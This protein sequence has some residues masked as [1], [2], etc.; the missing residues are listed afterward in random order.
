[1]DI[2]PDDPPEHG[3]ITKADWKRALN[4]KVA[5]LN[6]LADEL[7]AAGYREAVEQL[8]GQIETLR[9]VLHD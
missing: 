6:E 5:Y 7:T 1:L 3:M 4:G 8:R 9:K 2:Q